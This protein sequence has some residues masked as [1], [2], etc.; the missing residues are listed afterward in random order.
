MMMN[1]QS[2]P[3]ALIE[4]VPLFMYSDGDTQQRHLGNLSLKTCSYSTRCVTDSII[5]TCYELFE[6]FLKSTRIVYLF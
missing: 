5:N 4:D 3:H 6:L 1:S 2:I